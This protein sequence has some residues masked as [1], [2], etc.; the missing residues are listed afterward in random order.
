MTQSPNTQVSLIELLELK[1]PF[2]EAA[3]VLRQVVARL[4]Q[5]GV[6]S[7]VSMQFHADRARS[8]LAVIIT[9]SS[10]AQM[11]EH[12]R[13]IS[14]WEE[15]RRFTSMFKLVDMRI[16]GEPS[17]EFAAWLHQFG[18]PPHDFPEHVAGFAR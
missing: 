4:E 18:A 16:L 3:P 9:F 7:L 13:M 5:E 11:M 6:S 17:P 14:G 12:T 8:T 1:C 10:A 15:F 2:D